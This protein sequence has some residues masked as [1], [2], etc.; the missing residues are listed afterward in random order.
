LMQRV[1]RAMASA[2][3]LLAAG[4]RGATVQT[5][6]DAAVAAL[7]RVMEE[8]KNQSGQSNAKPQNRDQPRDDG[9]SK[10]EQSRGNRADQRPGGAQPGQPGQQGGQQPGDAQ[11]SGTPN[12][13]DP[14][15]RDPNGGDG[16]TGVNAEA[17]G[18]W[19]PQLPPVEREALEQAL[20]DNVPVEAYSLWRR[21]LELRRQGR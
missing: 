14:R 12:G 7:Y 20:Q 13:S 3:E 2:G 17:L 18:P 9:Q 11:A 8:A 16:A 6:Q 15:N 1:L 21:Y 4:E 10:N 5:E 19:V